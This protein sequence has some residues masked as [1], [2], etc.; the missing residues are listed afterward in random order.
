MLP[1]NKPQMTKP[2]VL[3]HLE[4]FNNPEY[5][6]KILGIRGYFKDTMGKKGTNDRGMYDDAIFIISPDGFFAYNGNTDPSKFQK[7]IAV[8]KAGG[9]YLYKIG[10]HNMKNPYKAL[11]QF[12]NVTVIRDGGKEVTDNPQARFY[13]DI[14]KGGF[15]TTSSLGCQTIHPNQWDDFLFKVEIELEQYH[16]EIVPYY[17]IEV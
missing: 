8:L 12:G 9:P 13:I 1:A 2:E 10:L 17:L 11:R 3:K 15:G 5:P 16:Q 6:V 14:H 4:A 7:G